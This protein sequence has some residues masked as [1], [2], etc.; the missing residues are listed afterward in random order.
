MPE[1]KRSPERGRLLDAVKQIAPVLESCA[2]EAEEIRHLP[3]KAVDAMLQADL[4]RC[5]APREVGGLETDPI[6]QTEVFEAVATVESNAGWNLMIGSLW[7]CLLGTRLP[8]A[9]AQTVFDGHGW[10]VIAGLVFPFGE[11][12]SNSDG[13][14][15]L[16]GRWK[17]GS[18]ISQASWVA[19]G[20]QVVD[21]DTVRTGPKGA[22]LMSVAVVPRA[23]V[24]VHDNWYTSGLRGTGSCDYSIDDVPVSDDFIFSGGSP[25]S[26]R[27]GAWYQQPGPPL[28]APGHSGF[29]L[30]IAKRCLDEVSALGDRRRYANPSKQAERESVQMEL[31]RHLAE[32]EAV[33]LFVFDRF[34]RGIETCERGE[35]PPFRPINVYATEMA[36]RCAEF[37]YRVMGSEAV[38][39]TSPVQRYL[40]DVLAAQQHLAAADSGFT[41]YGKA[42]LEA[43]AG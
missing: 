18:G 27:G 40:R 16:S 42:A 19:S 34:A 33:R 37:A 17:F 5:A 41:L 20:C 1:I 9:A 43:A 36:V 25:V 26:R 28:L 29:A 35:I 31:G 10:P 3:R 12:R 23:S 11:A 39:D 8:D 4:F 38:F 21:G 24:T 22:P 13:T 7:A 30:G 2:A 32:Y 6:T 14:H 15:H